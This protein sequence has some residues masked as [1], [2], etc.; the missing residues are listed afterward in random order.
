MTV[1]TC[2]L[3]FLLPLSHAASFISQSSK[4]GLP[5]KTFSIQQQHQQQQQQ[6]YT[7]ANGRILTIT[8]KNKLSI[9]SPTKLQFFEKV[10]EED[11]PLGKGITVGKVQVALQ[12][13]DRSSSSIFQILEK[14]S[15]SGD[16]SNYALASLAQEV[17]L[18]LL[19]RKD[20]WVGACSQS[21]W[22]GG[23]DSGK[24]ESFFNDLAN[25]E[26]AKFEKEY[27]PGDDSEEKG[28]G[29]TI[30]VV[31]LVME[32]EGDNTEFERAGYSIAETQ[33][34]LNSIASD[35][36]VEDGDLVN[37]VEV[38]WTPGEKSEV[39]TRTDVIIDFPELIDI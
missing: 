15:D 14:A 2:Y 12:A 36:M 26:A 37:A 7:S 5:S 8:N 38:F 17:C 11:G 9:N 31:S 35:A 16:G 32:I 10:F 27:F 20:E 3:L 25:K 22:F 6:Q 13:R 34:V 1:I 19:R 23:D 21:K 4:Y 24:A 33:K 30:A 28:G 18:S 39:L 29:P